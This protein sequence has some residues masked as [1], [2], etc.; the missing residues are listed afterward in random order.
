MP[1]AH[2]LRLQQQV[3]QRGVPLAQ[4]GALV[5]ARLPAHPVRCRAPR[6]HSVFVSVCVCVCTEWVCMQSEGW[7]EGWCARRR[8]PPCAPSALPC[9]LHLSFIHTHARTRTRPCAYT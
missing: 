5:V 1:R 3:L 9:P 2:L 4:D 7:R 6:L 8:T